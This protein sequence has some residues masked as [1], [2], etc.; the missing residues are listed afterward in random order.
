M[1]RIIGADGK[2]YGPVT[3]EQLRQWIAQGRA[4]GDTRVLAEGAT[5]WRPLAMLP[6]FSLAFASAASAVPVF[7]A[8]SRPRKTHPM[9]ITGL[10][11]GIIALT[12]GLCCCYGLPFNLIGLICSLI[13]LTQIRNNPQGYNGQGV[14]ITGVILSAFSLLL[15]FGLLLFVGTTMDWEE[16]TREIRSL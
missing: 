2:E 5:D 16:I 14:A 11:L 6:E 13:A 1:Y 9:A 3:A 10:I 7:A 12:I 8:P 15:A 4:N